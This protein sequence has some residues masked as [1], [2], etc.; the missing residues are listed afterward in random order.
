MKLQVG[1]ELHLAWAGL[2][3]CGMGRLARPVP[4]LLKAGGKGKRR[5]TLLQ[6]GTQAIDDDL[7]V[8]PIRQ[9]GNRHAADH[10][11]AAHDERE[12]SA[13]TGVVCRGDVIATALQPELMGDPVRAAQEAPHG[14]VLASH[15]LMVVGAGPWPGGLEQRAARWSSGVC[16]VP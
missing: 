10:P 12:A 9:P 15:P 8:L 14:V 6:D 11:S 5:G 7:M 2:P 16:D 1:T 3:S 13:D 4:R